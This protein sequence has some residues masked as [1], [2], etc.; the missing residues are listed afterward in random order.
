[1]TVVAYTTTSEI[2]RIGRVTLDFDYTRPVRDSTI[3]A[4]EGGAMF[5]AVQA[6]FLNIFMTADRF[7]RR[8]LRT[9]GTG[10][11]INSEVTSIPPDHVPAADFGGSR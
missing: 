2:E 1:M 6:M 3:Q 8:L 4:D 9:V 11:L 10:I 7:E 5:P